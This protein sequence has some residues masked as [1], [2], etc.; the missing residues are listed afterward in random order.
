MPRFLVSSAALVL[1]IGFI[2]LWERG[3]QAKLRHLRTDLKPGQKLWEGRSKW[4]QVNVFSPRNYRPEAKP[5]LAGLAGLI[6]LRA[7]ASFVL[8]VLVINKISGA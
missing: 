4:I 7:M 5:L 8:L 6:L 3:L 1:E 2:L